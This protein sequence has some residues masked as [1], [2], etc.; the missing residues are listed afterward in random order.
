MDVLEKYHLN[1]MELILQKMLIGLFF[2]VSIK[3]G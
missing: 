3:I 2:Q 1:L